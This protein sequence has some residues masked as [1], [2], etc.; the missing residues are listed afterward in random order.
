MEHHKET[1]FC[2]WEGP[3]SRDEGMGDAEG[4]ILALDLKMNQVEDLKA[5][6]RCGTHF[7]NSLLWR[8]PS[9]VL[10]GHEITTFI[11]HQNIPS[12]KHKIPP[13]WVLPT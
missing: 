5:I 12:K 9:Q 11:C 2:S 3:E 8:N 7:G 10:G 4:H 13:I 1:Q 6:S